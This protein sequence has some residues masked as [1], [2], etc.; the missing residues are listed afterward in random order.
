MGYKIG[1]IGAGN[2][3]FA[4][5]KAIKKAG[6]ASSIIASDINAKRI[7]FVKKQTGIDAATNNQEVIK[8]S[9]IVFIAVKPQ[10]VDSVLDEDEL[11]DTDKLV[12]SIAAGI[13][14]KRLEKKLKKARVVRVM[15]NTACLVGEMAAGFSTGKKCKAKDIDIV[16]KL[17]NSAG[18]SYYVK[19]DLLD[20]ITGLAGSGPAFVARF[21]EAFI[22]AGKKHGLDKNIATDLTLQTFRGTAKLLQELKM[23]PDELVNMVSS[24]QGTTAAGRTILEK[25]DYKTIII[26]TIEKAVKRSQELGK[27]EI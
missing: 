26:K 10:V 1:F 5:I 24:P 4:L 19:E 21:I 7:D 2:M 11:K 13:K 18:K 3:A 25:S 22:E 23:T 8:K 17:L 12:I 14:L 20:I 15:P 16:K 9:D 27:Q 6:L